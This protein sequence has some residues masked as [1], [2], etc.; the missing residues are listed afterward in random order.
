MPKESHVFY[1]QIYISVYVDSGPNLPS[2]SSILPSYALNGLNASSLY[3]VSLFAEVNNADKV[4]TGGI[5]VKAKVTKALMGAVNEISL[6]DD[7]LT[8]EIIDG[9]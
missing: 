8:S 3:A 9:Q 1:L 6:R 2:L 5:E 4:T 7:G